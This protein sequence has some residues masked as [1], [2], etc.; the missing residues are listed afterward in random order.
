MNVPAGKQSLQSLFHSLPLRFHFKRILHKLNMESALHTRTD[1]K[2]LLQS[3]SE[4]TQAVLGGGGC[5]LTFNVQTGSSREH[6]CWHSR[7]R[8]LLCGG[9]SDAQKCTKTRENARMWPQTRKHNLWRCVYN[10]HTGLCTY[11]CTE[12]SRNSPCQPCTIC[13]SFCASQ[14][15]PNG[16]P[17]E[18]V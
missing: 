10:I 1:R 2:W 12:D 5:F 6:L 15:C 9:L 16:A 4:A 18:L 13:L 14:P 8:A 17:A 3:I 7:K 11:A